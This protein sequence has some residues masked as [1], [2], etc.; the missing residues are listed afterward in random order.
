MKGSYA[1]FKR[2]EIVSGWILV[3]PL[4]IGFLLFTAIPLFL[5]VYYS[6]F[7]YNLAEMNFVGFDNFVKVLQDSMFWFGMRNVG[8]YCL[9]VPVGVALALITAACIKECTKG[10]LAFR[11]IFY[12]PCLCSAVAIT[13]IWQYMYDP[14]GVLSACLKVFGIQHKFLIEENF[15]MSMMI[16]GVW[17][18]VGVNVLM[19]YATMH[20]ISNSLY[21]AASLDG[22]NGVQKFFHITIPGVSSVSFYVLMTGIVGAAQAFAQFQVMCAGSLME[23][24]ATPVWYIYRYTGATAIR[25]GYASALGVVFGLILLLIT[26]IQFIG[27]KY[28]VKNDW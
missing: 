25:L 14:S 3:A 6:F 26:A 24:S 19:Y 23:Y 15:M 27:S 5:A 4:L 18:G 9:S 1:T 10:S 7:T 13:F 21:E 8:I 20:G 11:M 22:A 2:Q 17:S 16:M 12:I 28:W